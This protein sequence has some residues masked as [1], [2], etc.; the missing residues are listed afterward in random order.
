MIPE[1]PLAVCDQD[2]DLLNRLTAHERQDPYTDWFAGPDYTRQLNHTDIIIKSPGIPFKVLE[3]TGS[4]AQI[5]SQTELFLQFFRHQIRGITGTKG[6]STTAALLHHIYV[7]SG[8][9]SLFLGNIGVPPF[10]MIDQI[11][12]DTRI[13]YEMSS[14]QLEQLQV[15]P[16]LAVMLN[17]FPE[18]LD[19]YASF[20]HYRQA[21]LNISRWQ[22]ASD[23]LIYNANNENLRQ[24]IDS[25]AI[26]SRKV[27]IQDKKTDHECIWMQGDDLYLHLHNEVVCIKGL[28]HGITLAGIH[29]RTN[30]AAAASLAWLSG[31]D[32]H[33]ICQAVKSF[34]G[35]PHRL[36]LLATRGNARFINDSISTIP[37][38]TIAAI[39][40]F[41]D[42]KT[43]ILGGYDRGVDYNH[44]IHFLA[45]TTI[46]HFIFTGQAGLRM[47]QMV[48]NND[49]FLTK[50]CHFHEGFD[51][52]VLMAIDTLNN[53]GTCLLSPAAASYDSFR[54]FKERGDRFR[55]L[56]QN[57][58]N[59]QIS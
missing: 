44:L 31:V 28:Y 54:N 38:S 50:N 51:E 16:H 30:I 32:Q 48:V 43:L 13:T 34:T 19:H 45:H 47:Y 56:V 40:A 5:T 6:K 24:L 42:T 29:N 27:S 55:E 3:A 52:A 11:R 37:E 9:H 39:E 1:L 2:P 4:Q 33:T 22:T 21:K 23:L 12:P 10:D 14:H 17:I 15:S 41:P 20:E 18:H 8:D 53:E 36:E 46:S 26:Q 25:E 7:Q 57:W 49:S 59:K 58:L 35:L